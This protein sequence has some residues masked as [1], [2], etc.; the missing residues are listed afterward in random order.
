M[1]PT[2]GGGPCDARARARSA[3]ARSDLGVH[4]DGY[5]AVV[6]HTAVVEPDAEAPITGSAADVVVATHTAASV[7]ARLIK[8]GNTNTQ[9]TAALKRVADAFGVNM[10]QGTLSHQMKQCVARGPRRQLRGPPRA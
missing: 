10:V 1:A 8:A 7:A 3:T 6:A 5:I 9:V 4:I 2:T